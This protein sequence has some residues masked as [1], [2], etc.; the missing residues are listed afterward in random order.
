MTRFLQDILR[1]PQE[2]QRTLD[3]LGGPGCH[4]LQSAAAAMRKASHIYMTGMGGSWHAALNA[5]A[6]LHLNGFPAYTLDACDLLES[7]S[8]PQNAVVVILSRSGR[9]IEIGPLMELA[10]DSGAIVVGITNNP[11]GLLAQKADIAMV[12]PATPDHGIS[13]NTFSTLNL[14]AGALA[15]GTAGLFNDS[16]VAMLSGAFAKASRMLPAWKQ[17]IADTSWLMP[18]TPY[19]FL[20][21]RSSFGSAQEARLLWEEGA[22]TPATAMGT[23]SFR[24][25][26]QEVVTPDIRFCMWIDRGRTRDQDLTIAGDLKKLGA[27]V[28]LIGQELPTGV[29]ALTLQLPMVPAE[30]QFLLDV[31]PTQ[32]AAERLSRLSHVDCDAFRF[33]SFI[34]EDDFGLL[35][36]DPVES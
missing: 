35:R 23:G 24:H 14:A 17:Q 11:D 36:P 27:Q 28:M 19:Y 30:W 29:G 4:A 8:L 2:L 26:P 3:F 21:R 5:A 20:A 13:V 18:Q 12:V 10:H 32:L 22:K 34:V 9:S 25:G 31:I 1:Q 6:I 16:T 33:C 15:S 7:A